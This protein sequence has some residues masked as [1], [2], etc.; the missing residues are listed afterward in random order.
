MDR[1]RHILTVLG[2]RKDLA[3]VLLLMIIISVMILPLPTFLMD[4][5]IVLN[6]S[7]TVL[8][9]MVSIYLHRADDFS[10]FPT[11]ILLATTFRLAISI[12]TTRLILAH[13]DAGKIIETFGTFV[14]QGS[15]VVGLV[16]FIIITTVQFIVVTKGA[17]RVAEVAARFTLDA[18]PGRQ[19]SIDA[20]LRNGDITAE[21]AKQQR[22]DLEKENKFFGA[23]DGAMKFVKGD[24]IAGIII[25]IVNL[26]GGFGIGTVS[27]GLSAAEAAS[28]YSLLTVGDGLV[29]QIPALLLA[30]C[31]GMVITRVT[32]QDK[33][34][35]GSDIIGQLANSSKTLIVAGVIIGALGFIPGF[36]IVFFLISSAVFIGSGYVMYRR[37]KAKQDVGAMIDS[38]KAEGDVLS[39]DQAG[40]GAQ[41]IQIKEED[42][43]S[44]PNDVIKIGVGSSLIGLIDFKEF[45]QRRDI[46]LAKVIEEMG[47]FPPKFGVLEKQHFDPLEFEISIEGVSVF[48]SQM[49]EDSVVVICE[50]EVL[51]LLNIESMPVENNWPIKSA[52]WIDANQQDK[53]NDAE[54]EILTYA[55]ILSDISSYYSVK[56]AAQII[57]FEQLEYL[58]GM[59]KN[60]HPQLAAEVAQQV[61]LTQLLEIV[62]RLVDES[63]PIYS[64]RLLFESLIDSIHKTAGS[65]DM[66]EH[67]RHGLRRQICKHFADS[68][69]SI[70]AYIV[71]PDLEM[72]LRKMLRN[73]KD[74]RFLAIDP[75]TSNSIL[76]QL[77]RIENIEEIGVI[78][79]VLVT[80]A[81]IRPHLRKYLKTHKCNINVI[82]FQE[83]SDEFNLRPVGTISLVDGAAKNNEDGGS[84]A[85]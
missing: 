47:Q 61:N 80:S 68:D 84:K 56:N 77:G 5:L 22:K 79:P 76:G 58:L 44:K 21:Q 23:M 16:I 50:K 32:T 8:I 7:L 74:A 63:V 69:N 81:D 70:A 30:I 13:A 15:V 6:M 10:V 27:K 24:A 55:R 85:A 25:I 36:P 59:L 75:Q 72:N 41:E 52:F 40:D 37:E 3:L 67:I 18:M 33:S 39:S 49:K 38:H 11:V 43:F 46:Y 65:V 31:A 19:M 64:R 66:S 29:S 48:S 1:V 35:L 42:I 26:A 9:L 78:A 57:G 12:S 82:A 45:V 83:I 62:R 28:V 71:E 73:E 51:D 20:E 60:E 17:E 4:A 2:T 53:L 34:D 14:T 54:A